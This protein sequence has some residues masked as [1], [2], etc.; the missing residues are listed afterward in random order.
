MLRTYGPIRAAISLVVGLLAALAVLGLVVASPVW[1]GW[2]RRRSTD[3]AQLA[4]VGQAYG[5][6]SAILSAFALCAV[7]FSILVQ[8]LQLRTAALDL[9]RRRHL[10][11][12][13]IALGDDELVGV[14]S[15]RLRGNPHARAY[16]YANLWVS[17][18][19]T[20]WE[21]GRL[22]EDGLRR[23]A[24][25]MFQNPVSRD[26]WHGVEE[27]WALGMRSR[28]TRRFTDVLTEICNEKSI[29]AARS[30][31]VQPATSQGE[32]HPRREKAG[33]LGLAASAAF[34]AIVAVVWARRR[35]SR[36]E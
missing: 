24:A 15:P 26:W 3:W 36:S 22:G 28:R 27:G 9:D 2:I 33:G 30:S 31:H 1:M 10:D 7:A 18:W 34:G 5:G 21:M 19:F 23:N 25:A 29:V 12:I 32:V 11:L 6:V 17:Y 14:V 8:R 13:Q 4:D 16:A 20:L 35:A